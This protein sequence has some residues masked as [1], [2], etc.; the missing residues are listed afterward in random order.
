M[1]NDLLDVSG[2]EAGKLPVK[3]ETFSLARLVEEVKAELESLVPARVEVRVDVAADLPELESDRK[4]VKQILA[5]LLSNALKFTAEGRVTVDARLG[6]TDGRV[7]IA[8]RDTGIGIP[9]ERQQTIFEPFGQSETA[10][11]PIQKGTGLGL[12]ICRRM[13]TLL[14]GSVRLESAFGR[15]STFTL[16]LPLRSREE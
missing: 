3:V 2:I 16:E 1:I 6:P 9:V 13:A 4:K 15:G 12:S 8:V 14:G 5:N 11:R 10:F 7:S